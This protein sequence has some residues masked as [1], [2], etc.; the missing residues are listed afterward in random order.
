MNKIVVILKV[1]VYMHVQKSLVEGELY[2]CDRMVVWDLKYKAYTS[3]N[4]NIQTSDIKI[5]YLVC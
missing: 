4:L 3:I 1:C 2:F 5:T